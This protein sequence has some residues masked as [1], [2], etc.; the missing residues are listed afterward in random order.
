MECAHGKLSR[1]QIK[2]YLD[3][4]DH[5]W[6]INVGQARAHCSLAGERCEVGI[7]LR[8]KPGDIVQVRSCCKIDHD[9]CVCMLRWSD[10]HKSPGWSRKRIEAIQVRADRSSGAPSGRGG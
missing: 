7:P 3:G 4:D 9:V 1:K 5:P 10:T 6:I 2:F 8:M